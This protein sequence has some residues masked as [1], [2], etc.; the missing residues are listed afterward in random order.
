M[1]SA[2][3]LGFYGPSVRRIHH[4]EAAKIE[5]RILRL[6]VRDAHTAEHDHIIGKPDCGILRHAPKS[7]QLLDRDHRQSFGAQSTHI[8][9]SIPFRRDVPTPSSTAFR[10]KA[11]SW[12]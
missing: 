6:L 5:A 8:V 3:T 12:A 10:E 1:R 11:S 2:G 4:D 9:R 7:G